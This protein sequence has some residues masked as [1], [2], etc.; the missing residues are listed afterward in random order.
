MGNT[1]LEKEHKPSPA[2]TVN[3]TPDLVNVKLI[4]SITGA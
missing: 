4:E 3:K 1:V 2:T